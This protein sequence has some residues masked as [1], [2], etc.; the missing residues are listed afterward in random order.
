[1][2]ELA[3]IGPSSSGDARPAWFYRVR[4]LHETLDQLNPEFFDDDLSEWNE[5]EE[6]MIRE[7]DRNDNKDDYGYDTEH[8]DFKRLRRLRFWR[9]DDLRMRQTAVDAAEE[10]MK[11]V[12][13]AYEAFINSSKKPPHLA[14][15]GD[16]YEL[17]SG[18]YVK[19]FFS[20]DDE[21]YWLPTIEFCPLDGDPYPRFN[22]Q[23]GG[24]IIRGL[25]GFNELMTGEVKPFAA[26]E[27]ASAE[28]R[29]LVGCS[30]LDGKNQHNM[31]CQFFS[32]DYLKLTVPRELVFLYQKTPPGAPEFFDFMGIRY[33]PE[34][35][36]QLSQ[37]S[38][39]RRRSSSSSLSSFLSSS[40]CPTPSRSPSPRE[41]WFEMDHPIGWWNQEQEW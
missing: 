12:E 19:H 1:M 32:R 25:I 10:K 4:D 38:K 20:F 18:E 41:T 2:N 11:E 16:R 39:K 13:D 17:Y 33:K 30:S 40:L 8:R 37:Q 29:T 14:V 28:E 35:E 7:D 9:K 5:E 21:D 15:L 6:K 27:H 36:P 26:P 3:A 24:R 34:G 22:Q 31:A 23:L